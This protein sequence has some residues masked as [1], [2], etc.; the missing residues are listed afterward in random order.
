MTSSRP[1]AHY[2]VT[3]KIGAGA[4]GE[5]FRATD[6]RLGRE[7]ALKML[8]ERLA[9]HPERLARFRREAQVLAALNHPGIA[10]IYGL[11]SEDDRHAL[12]MELVDGPDLAE[13]LKDGPLAVDEALRVALE[14]AE[15]VEAAH[16]KGIIHRD[17]KPANIK[18]T[19][20]GRVKVLDFGLA[21]ALGDDPA[22]SG[23][24]S[25][26]SPTLTSNM[27]LDN[28]IL[29]TAAY[30]SPEQARG[31]DVDKRA[32]IWAFGVVLVEMLGGRSLFGGETVSDTL[33]SVLQAPI[34]L[35]GLPADLPAAVTR[36]LRRCL[37]RDPR[38]RL[39]DM[40][41]A[42]LVLQDV[43]AGESE[44]ET[45][46]PSARVNSWPLR[47]AAGVAVLALAAAATG[48]LRPA[49]APP[50][51]L[52][53]FEIPLDAT[54]PSAN[55]NFSPKISPDGRFLLY[56]SQDRIRVR[57]LATTDSR[58]L[59]GTDGARAPFWSP[60]GEWIG[61]GTSEALMK[62]DRSGGHAMILATVSGSQALGGGGSGIW[63]PDGSIFYTTSNT[64][65]LRSS[66]QARE[67]SM[68]LPP[69][70]GEV[71][72]HELC[73]LP[74]GRGWIYVVHTLEDYGNLD[75]LTPDG[76]TRRLLTLTGDSI[77]TPVYSPSGHLIFHREGVAAGIWAVPFSL[78][79]LAVTGEPFL[80]APE[81]KNPSVSE[82]GTLVYAARAQKSRQ[83]LVW[84]DREGR[85]L[86]VI[87]ELETNRPYPDLSP[88]GRKIL[89]A[90]DAED[91]RELWLYDAD[92]GTERRL[93][94]E[95]RTWGVGVW[96]PDGRRFASYTEP[97]YVGKL[98]TLDGSEPPRDLGPGILGSFSADGETRLY[99]FPRFER[100]FEFDIHARSL[101]EGPEDGR[102]LVSTPA[103]EWFPMLSP[104]G[105][106][107]L[108]DSDES[109]RLEVYMTT[110]PGLT[111]RWLVSRDGGS[112]ARWRGDSREIYYTTDRELYAVSLTDDDGPV[113]GRPRK[114]FDRP[115]T[116]WSAAWPDGFDVTD[117]G[118][119]FVMLRP[120]PDES[121]E[122]P[123]LVVVQNW[124]AEFA[125]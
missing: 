25:S 79:D 37:Q 20:E 120:A 47:I 93:T 77:N 2:T 88:D 101:D 98:F 48:L 53:K 54:D 114:L 12:A 119:R 75:L 83:Q 68:H 7:V 15:A 40:G 122:Q 18:L 80:V 109:G 11:E 95:G 84:Y 72:F 9:D 78:D 100:G 36:L 81:A 60:D 71:D 14:L 6:S 110:Y 17:L 63:N 1:F 106:Y 85:E 64:G 57:D 38:Q 124:Y 107:L 112:W 16:E 58:A 13:R 39:R 118:E 45:A 30:M 62:I 50:L 32:D 117:D 70:E 103:L 27:T 89:I 125:H 29:G 22:G 82:D 66:A 102:P 8:P 97:D 92:N 42:R 94:F 108:Y 123:A 28:A 105:K 51:P 91:H 90:A 111:G 10:A 96:H 34:D 19:D 104:D 46:A 61:Y 24:D 44:D 73:R 41:D 116:N 55:A 35:N 23:I 69:G 67:I 21:K 5:V 31:G 56:L 52:R 4:M 87:A 59:P 76:E 86:G 65:I 33:A 115:T 121:E 26:M 43:I 3:D 49:S 74:R 113:L 99:S